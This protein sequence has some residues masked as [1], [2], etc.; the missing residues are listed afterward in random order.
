MLKYI[1]TQMQQMNK[2]RTER[3]QF[4]RDFFK[5]GQIR[6][7]VFQQLEKDINKIYN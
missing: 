4:W 3:R 2:S 5:D 7:D 6:I 1:D